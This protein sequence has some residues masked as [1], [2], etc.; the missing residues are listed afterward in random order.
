M[1]SSRSFVKHA[2]VYGLAGL[3][4][5]AGGF[6]LLPLYT[7]CLTPADYGVLEVLSRI[8]ETVGTCLMFGGFRQALLTFYQQSRNE[9]ERC[10]VVATTLSLFGTTTLVGGGLV[11]ALAGPFSHLINQSMHG[12]GTRLSAG[13]LRLAVLAILLEPL[14]QAPLI[15]LQARVESVRLV[16]IT[17]AQFLLRITLCVWF[18]KFLHGGVAGALASSALVGGLFGLVLCLREII[19]SPGRPTLGY[20]RSLLRFSLPLVPGGLCFFLLHHGDRFFLLRYR[21]MQEVGTYALGYKLAL[22][23]GMFSLSPLYMVWSSQMYKV[24]QEDN[25]PVVFGT[26]ITR[27]LAAYLLVALALALFQDE[28]VGFLS[29]AGYAEA[30]AVV[31]PVLLAYFFQSAASLMDAGLYV[32]HR[33]GL[34]LC[35]TLATTT[36][37]LLLYAVL[38]PSWGSMGAAVATLIGFAFLA[39]CTWAVSRRVFPVRYEW[40]RLAA[41]LGLAVGLW[42]LSRLLPAAAWALPVKAG[43]WLLAPILV[44]A[45]G[46]ISPREKEH[47][48][49]LTGAAGRM[50]DRLLWSRR[51]RH[52]AGGIQPSHPQPLSPA[53]RG[54]GVRG[55]R[56]ESD[57]TRGFI[58]VSPQGGR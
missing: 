16:T 27:I 39:A 12:G 50:L 9:R 38:I 51:F 4:V 8:A 47:V 57:Q 20:L 22:A 43:L 24:A 54:A 53:G 37:M 28:L 30:S 33:T 14:S 55:D 26:V 29:G 46:L 44:W 23:V 21:S 11:L 1:I 17:I 40:P 19:R 32:R 18:V 6:V 42:L 36:V 31:A 13:L 10:Q 56:E 7:H 49:A 48:R 45:T 15:L 3:L 2:M 25:A 41:L 52:P 35:V 58:G 5:Q 34:K